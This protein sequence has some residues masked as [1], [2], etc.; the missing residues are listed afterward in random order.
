MKTQKRRS[1]T[2]QKFNGDSEQH[3]ENEIKYYRHSNQINLELL[4]DIKECCNKTLR[5]SQP[6]CSWCN[7]E[8]NSDAQKAA[9]PLTK[10]NILFGYSQAQSPKLSLNP[11]SS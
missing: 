5:V 10:A 7:L 9:N 4:G 6:Q 1:H 2:K 11:E 8:L 3:L